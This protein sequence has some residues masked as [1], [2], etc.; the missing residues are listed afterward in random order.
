MAVFFALAVS[1]QGYVSYVLAYDDLRLRLDQFIS[2]RSIILAEPM[3]ESRYD[4]ISVIVASMIADADIESVKIYDAKG[5]VIDSYGEADPDSVIY[6]KKSTITFADEAAVR[7]VGYLEILAGNENLLQHIWRVIYFE[8]AMGGVFILLAIS[9]TMIGYR[10]AVGIPLEYLR[11]AFIRAEPEQ[12][13][14]IDGWHAN[15]EFGELIQAYNNMQ[16]KLQAEESALR[17]IRLELETRVEERTHELT[18]EITERKQAE[19]ALLANETRFRDFAESASDRF[20][21][22]DE[23]HRFTF[24]SD[25]SDENLVP[26]RSEILGMTRWAAAGVIPDAQE[27]WRNHL[28]DLDSRRPFRD[29]VFLH[30]RPD[31]NARHFSVSGIPIFDGD[32]S[33]KGYRGSA[34]DITNRIEVENMK[35]EFVSTVSHEL[36][37]PLTSIHGSLG[38]VTGGAVGEVPA[39]ARDLIEIAG[40][41]C[42]R[43]IA[44]VND[45]LDMEK[46][47]SGRMEYKFDLVDLDILVEQAIRANQAYG[48]EFDVAFVLTDTETGAR[49]QGDGERLTQVLANLLSNAA[50]FSPAGEDVGIS[51]TRNDGAFRVSVKD[52][53]NGVPEEFRDRIFEKFSQADSSD[54]RQGGGTGLGLSISKAIVDEHGGRI[55]FDTEIGRGTTF[56]FDLPAYGKT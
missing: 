25:Q 35:S 33:F 9:I 37:T 26:R 6:S 48:S 38:L 24:V 11:R 16:T 12:D 27:H 23:Q 49:V 32:G 20:W 13:R 55:D 51:I 46:I 28:A 1:L 4:E 30:R 56:Y 41:N 47:E 39:Q 44:L 42:E 10:R 5:R 22:T 19:A 34:T 45:I 40:K 50:K 53:G 2:S 14:T 17:H 15:D 43:L 8:A 31:G 3:A 29:F 21:E 18:D 7:K 36:R 52:S 54:A